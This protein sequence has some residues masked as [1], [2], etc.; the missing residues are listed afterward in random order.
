MELTRSSSYALTTSS[1]IYVIMTQC[2]QLGHFHD[3]ATSVTQRFDATTATKHINFQLIDFVFTSHLPC[4]KTTPY[5]CCCC[6]QM[7]KRYCNTK[8]TLICSFGMLHVAFM[9]THCHCPFCP[10]I[11]C[12]LLPTIRQTGQKGTEVKKFISRLAN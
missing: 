10:P 2:F 3:C 12:S 11:E 9:C 4:M 5:P 6:A 8:G 7:V 1:N